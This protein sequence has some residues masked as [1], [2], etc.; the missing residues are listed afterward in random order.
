MTT[1]PIST[2]LIVH[3]HPESTSFSTAQ[4]HEVRRALEAQGFQVDLLDLYAQAWQPVL[5]RHEFPAFDGP[6]KPQREQWSAVRD[7]TLPDDVRSDLD[8]VLAAD[9]LVL[10][11]PLWWF[12]MPAILKGWLDRVFVMGGV[13]GGDAGLFETARL[14]G[15]RAVVLATT[16]GPAAAFT[17]DGAFGGID[18]FLFHIHRGVF[19]FVGYDALAPV[20]TYGPAHLDDAARA[21]A[22]RAAADAFRD[23][24][25]RPS[26]ATS[27]AR[28]SL[29]G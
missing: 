8:R 27:R 3:A 6:F 21:D 29:A 10:S 5:D 26:A 1:T 15:R 13:A 9:L 16:G 24:E 25:H 4:A 17:P 18:E 11:F 7:G 20:I 28:G 22:L 23:I 14:A 19:E 2:V 12:S